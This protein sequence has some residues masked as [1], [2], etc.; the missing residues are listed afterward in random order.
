MRTGIICIETEFKIIS[1]RKDRIDMDTESLLRFMHEGHQI[2]FIYRRVATKGELEYYLH[3]FSRPEYMKNYGILYFSF[4]GS[5]HSIY[6]EGDKIEL[7]LSDLAELGGN[8][9]ENRLVHF[10]SCNTMLGSQA[11]IENFKNETGAKLVSG[12]SKKVD[13]IKS[14]INDICLF[15]TFI[16]Y[17]QT[18]SITNRMETV[19]GGLSKELGFKII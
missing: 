11:V 8:V 10:S 3:Q 6:L 2:P 1:K 14:A 7:S 5:T 18:P 4:H 15:D 9:F 17:K 19:Y 16:R 13:A 12:Y